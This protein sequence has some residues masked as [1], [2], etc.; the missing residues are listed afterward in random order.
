M[1]CESDPEEYIYWDSLSRLE[2]EYE[3]IKGVNRDAPEPFMNNKECEFD[4][5]PFKKVWD[6]IYKTETFE[7]A[8]KLSK[9]S[10]KR[11]IKLRKEFITKFSYFL[12][13]SD[14]LQSQKKLEE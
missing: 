12:S 11:E 7:D 6:N 3:T 1:D 5:E 9:D 13:L 14:R 10:K 8:L 4:N 2:E